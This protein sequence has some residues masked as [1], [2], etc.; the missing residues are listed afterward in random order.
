MKT[1]I[2]KTLRKPA[3]TA[4][5]LL[6]AVAFRAEAVIDGVAG[7]TFNLT[8]GTASIPTPDGDSVLIWGYAE[9]G[10]VQ[11]PGPTLI[12]NQGDTVTVNLNNMLDEPTSI[13]FP[14][15]EGVQA[16]CTL[17]TC[18]SG[19]LTMESN[20]S[21]STVQYTFTATHAGTYLYH[22]GSN[23]D[24]QQEMGLFGT[25]IVRPAAASEAY[26]SPGTDYDHE[27]LFV[28]SEMDPMIHLMVE[29]GFKSSVDFRNYKAVL[30][31]INGRNG[32]DTLAPTNLPTLPHQPYN[33]VP[34]AHP[35]DRVL[36]RM[37]SASR[38]MH[39]FHTHSANFRIIARDG[40]VRESAPGIGP[41][42]GRSD[43]T[44]KAVPGQTYDAIWQWTGE[45]LG[46]DIYGTVAQGAEPHT[47]CTDNVN[48]ETGAAGADG[49]DDNTWEW[50]ADHN[51]ALPVD[52]PQLKDM[53]FGGFWSGSPFLGNFGNLP[54]GEGGL[55]LTGG[56]FHIWHSHTEK[57]LVNNDVFPG[58]MM[59]FMIVEPPSVPIP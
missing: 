57:E 28:L 33:I 38:H 32:P 25:L 40:R 15:Q 41:D 6:S 50:V 29:F 51:K 34:R 13:V 36:M 26:D 17:G 30:W 11:Y 18:N 59:T 3:V 19:E 22:S 53:A 49:F 5:A 37:V 47:C 24:L 7:P 2:P 9:S 48:N 20:G 54:P 31:F 43:Y 56:L 21:G 35:G 39:P 46:W 27:Y 16:N 10:V 42:I 58:G 55:N 45:A 52:L 23:V 4:L 44:L 12:V 14:G 8:A 1:F